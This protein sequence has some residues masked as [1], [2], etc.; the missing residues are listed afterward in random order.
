MK[1]LKKYINLAYQHKSA[2]YLFYANLVIGPGYVVSC[3]EYV[4][5]S[6]VCLMCHLETGSRLQKCVGKGMLK[7]KY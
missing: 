3:G 1:S 2:V 6:Q 7:N 5:I 4:R